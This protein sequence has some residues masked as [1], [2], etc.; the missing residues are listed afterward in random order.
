ML[1][2][3]ALG[4]I[5]EQWAAIGKDVP[6]A[7]AFGVPPAAIMASSMPLPDGVSEAEYVGCMTGSGLE[8]VRCE[9]NDLHVPANAEIVLEGYMSTTEKGF[10]GPYGEMHGYTF[11]GDSHQSPLFKVNTITY[12]DDAIL[13]M[14][15]AGRA[16]DETVRSFNPHMET[17]TLIGTAYF[18]WHS[19]SL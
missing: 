16:V 13:P 19:C 7:L 18:N 15:V 11:V 9:T 17:V 3:I 8:V 5:R 4:I 12:R 2:N 14:S 1:L 6:W 10:E